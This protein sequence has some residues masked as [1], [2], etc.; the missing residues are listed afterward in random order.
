MTFLEEWQFLFRALYLAIFAITSAVAIRVWA[1]RGFR[2]PLYIHV[3]AVLAFVVAAALV[4]LGLNGGGMSEGTA[5]LFLIGF[6]LFVYVYFVLHGGAMRGARRERH[7]LRDTVDTHARN[8]ETLRIQMM[9]EQHHPLET[10]RDVL[11]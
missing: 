6:P 11:S 8:A 10:H 5:L 4:W 3:L 1:Q 7:E 9:A 2:L